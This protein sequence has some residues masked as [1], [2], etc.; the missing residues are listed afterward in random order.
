M[1]RATLE[2][3]LE[4][5]NK[6]REAG[7]GDVI[8]ALMPS[9]PAIPESCLIAN[10]LNFNC[11]VSGGI[12]EPWYMM[13]SDRA[14]ARKIVD[15]LGLKGEYLEDSALSTRAANVY[16][17]DKIGHVARDFDRAADILDQKSKPTG[18]NAELVL[19]MWPYIKDTD[20]DTREGYYRWMVKNGEIV[21]NPNYS[22]P[23]YL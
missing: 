22:N 23:N 12:G 8:E 2:E 17:P 19:E 7:G 13:I 14:V 16:L 1:A 5:A 21:K 3:L 6:V 15:K 11:Q 4:F 18:R 10:A 20:S 9:N